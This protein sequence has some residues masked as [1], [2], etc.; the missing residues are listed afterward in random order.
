MYGGPMDGLEIQLD[1]YIGK[2]EF[3]PS[4]RRVEGMAGGKI[5]VVG[6]PLRREVYLYKHSRVDKGTE[7]LLYSWFSFP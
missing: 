7:Y 1:E 4:E 3:A 2:L 5:R 6:L